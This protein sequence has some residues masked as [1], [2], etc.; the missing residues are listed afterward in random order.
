[1]RGFL[2]QKLKNKRYT[3]KQRNRS[4][5]NNC[6]VANIECNIDM[7]SETEKQINDVEFLK[8]TIVSDETMSVIESKLRSTAT[9][10]QKMMETPELDL[11]ETFPY[12]FTEPKLVKALICH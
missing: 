9:Y 12:F 3:E 1:M 2:D 11:L 5:D 7:I 4:I 10:R 8:A 6:T